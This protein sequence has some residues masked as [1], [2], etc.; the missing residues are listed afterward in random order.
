MCSVM[1]PNPSLRAEL[2]LL[3]FVKLVPCTWRPQPL[4]ASGHWHQFYVVTNIPAS[5]L[6]YAQVQPSPLLFIPGL[7]S[8]R[9]WL[10]SQAS[11]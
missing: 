11:P 7:G 8:S 9:V 5:D 6:T 10:G 3:F 1:R 4:L 2:R